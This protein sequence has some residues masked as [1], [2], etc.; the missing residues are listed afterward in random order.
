MIVYVYPFIIED[1]YE[2]IFPV[3]YHLPCI[4]TEVVLGGGRGDHSPTQATLGESTFHTFPY[5]KW[6]RRFHEEQKEEKG[7]PSSLRTFFD[8]IAPLLARSTFLHINTLARPASW[9]NTGKAKQSE[10]ARVQLV[11]AKVEQRTF[12]R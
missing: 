9:V 5:K 11:P 6:A 10:H 12:N 2:L 1:R 4:A 7:D 8:S 3:R